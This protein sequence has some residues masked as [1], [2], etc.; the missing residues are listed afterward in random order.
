MKLTIEL[1]PKGAWRNNLRELLPQKDW[2][3][4][5]ELCYVRAKN[6]CS[7][8]GREDKQLH[9]HEVWDFDYVNK[10]QTLKDIIALCPACHGV[11]HFRNSERIGYGEQAKKHF[12]QI[13]KCGELE[14]AAYCTQVKATF[15]KLNE[16]LR[17]KI[18]ADLTSFGGEDMELKE[19]TIPFITNPYQYTRFSLYNEE[20]RQGICC[21]ITDNYRGEIIVIPD[22]A[23]KIKWET[24]NEI[25]K[26]DYKYTYPFVSVFSAKNISPCKLRFRLIDNKGEFVSKEF[27]LINI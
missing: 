8:C 18:I 2:N 9:A 11:K 19:R 14:F 16:V 12:M 3:K 15:D 13:N 21:V 10:T 7:I 24:E 26:T 6:R 17:W 1:I 25:L 4:L 5:R 27:S 23:Y 20:V 22:T